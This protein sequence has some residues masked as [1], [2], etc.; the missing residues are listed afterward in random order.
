MLSGLEGMNSVLI[1]IIVG[2]VT[3]IL[4]ELTTNAVVVAAFI[5]VLAGVGEAIGVSPFAM[6]IACMLACNFAFMLPP[7]TPPNAIVYGTGEIELKDMMKCGLGLKIIALIVF[8]SFCTSSPWVCSASALSDLSD[9]IGT[10]GERSAST[11]R[12]TF[13]CPAFHSPPKKFTCATHM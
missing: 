2:L 1:V 3:A 11:G 7:G 13:F 5:P 8:P 6:M 10:Y 4:T 9:R 12:G